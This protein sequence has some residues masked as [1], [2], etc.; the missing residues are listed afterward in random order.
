MRAPRGQT[1]WQELTRLLCLRGNIDVAE[2][3]AL[4]IGKWL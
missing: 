2:K 1:H 3:F 4:P